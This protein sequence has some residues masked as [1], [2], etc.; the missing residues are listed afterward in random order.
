MPDDKPYVDPNSGA[1]PQPGGFALHEVAED[2][3]EDKSLI[4]PEADPVAQAELE[5]SAAGDAA[6]GAASQVGFAG[7]AGSDTS[8]T[9]DADADAEADS[10]ADSDGDSDEELVD[11]PG[12][13]ASRDEWV[14]FAQTQG[15]TE[16]ETKPTD[17]GG[18][19]RDELRDKY[20]PKD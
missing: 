15:A 2:D 3:G 12:G 17:E 5:H 13:N 14:A 16:E 4:D 20:Q 7:A 18:L 19:K 10:D 11:V 9:E 8:E 6:G 1:A